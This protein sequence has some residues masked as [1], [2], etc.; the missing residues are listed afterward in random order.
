MQLIRTADVGSGVAWMYQA[1]PLQQQ[2]YQ[3]METAKH[4]ATFGWLLMSDVAAV[5]KQRRETRSQPLVG[6]SS[7]LLCCLTRF[8]RLLIHAL[9]RK[10]SRTKLCDGAQMAIFWRFFASYILASRVQHISDLHS[11]FVLRPHHV[12]KYGRHTICDGWD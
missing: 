6:R 10:Y 1:N 7:P 5:T 4:R 2:V 9:L 8:F 3:P 12:W 11:K